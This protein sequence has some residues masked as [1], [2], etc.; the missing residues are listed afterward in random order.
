MQQPSRT[1]SFRRRLRSSSRTAIKWAFSNSCCRST[2]LPKARG[3]RLRHRHH[4]TLLASCTARTPLRRTG[5]DGRWSG[6]LRETASSP[7]SPAAAS[8]RVMDLRSRWTRSSWVRRKPLK[9]SC[10]AERRRCPTALRYV[11]A[12][13]AV[14]AV[15][16]AGVMAAAEVAP[17]SS[18]SR[19]RSR[20]LAQRDCWNSRRRTFGARRL[21]GWRRARGMRAGLR[22]RSGF[23]SRLEV[24][25]KMGRLWSDDRG[26][27]AQMVPFDE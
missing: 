10:R 12:A 4:S 14:V 13:A 15:A 22:A 6:H 25:W 1:S 2:C 24:I 19:P 8:N 18:R 3:R 16:A 20:A 7:R 17:R 27:Y 5:A 26:F 9:S 11:R 23:C 21:L